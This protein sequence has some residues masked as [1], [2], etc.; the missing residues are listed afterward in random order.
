MKGAQR[1]TAD[2]ARS[3]ER[4]LQRCG[5]HADGGFGMVVRQLVDAESAFLARR[6]KAAGAV[7]AAQEGEFQKMSR[8]QQQSAVQATKFRQQFQ[9]R[10]E[11]EM[12][13][14]IAIDMCVDNVRQAVPTL[15]F[16]HSRKATAALATKISAMLGQ[17]IVQAEKCKKP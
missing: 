9:A 11:D 5:A 12:L 7:K 17:N 10:D 15:L 16:V 4:E 3:L 8:K 2:Q 6:K 13:D 14:Q 1:T